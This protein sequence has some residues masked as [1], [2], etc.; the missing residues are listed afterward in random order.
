MLNNQK[1]YS[2]YRKLPIHNLLAEEIIIGHLLSYGFFT[3]ELIYSINIYCFT[4]KKYQLLF[5]YGIKN[6]KRFHKHHIV[7]LIEKLWEKQILEDIGGINHIIQCIQKTQTINSL[8]Y[9]S[10]YLYL[11]YFIRTLHYYYIKR[12]F[13]QYSHHLIQLN[14]LYNYRIGNLYEEANFSLHRI[15]KIYKHYN[16]LAINTQIRTYLYN[17]NQS[18]N[19]RKAAV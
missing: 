1:Y 7:K 16:A 17:T 18:E 9:R 3:D 2:C 11:K 5:Q 12:L 15:N 13:I 14:Y 10:E 8:G 6:N 19:K 4:L